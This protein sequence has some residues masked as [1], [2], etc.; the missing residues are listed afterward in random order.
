[1]LKKLGFGVLT[2]T[3]IFL[4]VAQIDSAGQ[5]PEAGSLISTPEQIA[6]DLM[7]IP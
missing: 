6:A 3:L 4:R 1:M 7:K 5:Q 2:T